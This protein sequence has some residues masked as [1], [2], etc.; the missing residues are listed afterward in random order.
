MPPIINNPN[1]NQI[2]NHLN[3]Y[4]NENKI[5][6]L[7]INILYPMIYNKEL[8]KD[9]NTNCSICLENYIDQKSIISFTPCNH[10]FHY[11]CLKN[12]SFKNTGYFRCPNCNYDFMKENLQTINTNNLQNNNNNINNININILIIIL[13]IIILILVIII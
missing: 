12:W 8:L 5:K 7:F 4:E 9:N 3:R 11:D 1:N 6:L 10:I 13:I 2:I